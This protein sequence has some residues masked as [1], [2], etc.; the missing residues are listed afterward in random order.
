VVKK[1]FVLSAG[2]MAAVLA[3]APDSQASPCVQ[4]SRTNLVSCALNASLERRAGRAAVDAAT[5]RVAAAE[6][7]LPSNPVLGITGARRSAA[8]GRAVNWSANLGVEL[9]IGGQR[10]ARRAEA[11]ALRDARASEVTAT[12]REAAAQA[13]TAYFEVIAAREA[14]ELL[15]Q[16]EGGSERVW[17][18]A[19]AAAERGRTAGVEADIAESAY[20]NVVLRRKDFERQARAASLSL[21]LL[22]GLPAD[23]SPEVEGALEPLPAAE[24]VDERARLADPPRATALEAERRS[25]AA[26]A[27]TLRRSRVPNP[28]VSIFFE[29]DGFDENVFGLGL[30]L[31]L[32][33]PGPL[34]QSK[35]GEIVE[36]EALSQRAGALAEAVRRAAHAELL[37]A[38]SAYRTAREAERTFTA[39]RLTRAKQALASLADEVEGARISAREAVLLQNPLLELL[40]GAVEARKL[41]CLASVELVRA[42]GLPLDGG[43]P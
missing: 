24:R 17:L 20:L 18:A 21:A 34:G 11:L 2:L 12:E 39:E 16:L 40:L 1:Y 26:H 35:R 37:R 8:A 23:A 6:V 4:L 29:R 13:W 22:V 7:I 33:L 14:H 15:L 19:R 42:A 3:C 32:P 31:P 36:S 41:A 28:T 9:E 5:G 43:R 30:G 27:S 38:F 25:L 10:G